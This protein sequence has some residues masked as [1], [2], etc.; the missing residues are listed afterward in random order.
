MLHVFCIVNQSSICRAVIGVF[1]KPFRRQLV[2][3]DVNPFLLYICN[4]YKADN[5]LFSIG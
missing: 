5:R 4:G 1:G 2:I 3:I